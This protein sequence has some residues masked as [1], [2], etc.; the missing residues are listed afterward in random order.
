M[1]FNQIMFYMPLNS[2]EW[3]IPSIKKSGKKMKMKGSVGK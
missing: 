1:Q 2:W 3:K